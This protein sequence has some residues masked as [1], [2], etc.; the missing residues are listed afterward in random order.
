MPCTRRT[1][2]APSYRTRR[3]WTAG[4]PAV[5][6]PRAHR[7]PP[8]VC[9]TLAG[10]LASSIK[11]RRPFALEHHL[12][13]CAGPPRAATGPPRCAHHSA[14]S[15]RRSASLVAP[16]APTQACAA[17]CRPGRTVLRRTV[18]HRDW[19]RPPPP[20]TV[21][22]SALPSTNTPDRARSTHRPPCV[23]FRPDTAAGLAGISPPRRP[24]PPR[25][26]I[27]KKNFFSRA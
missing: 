24:P 12:P 5:V 10:E 13:L 2:R 1:P 27:A 20:S 9:W 23:H 22:G 8:S 26:D 4:P 11:A 21:A 14:G 17:A 18:G 6:R 15:P 3:L 16:L 19:L 25:G 7:G